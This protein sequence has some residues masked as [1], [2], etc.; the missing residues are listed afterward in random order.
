MS[1][2]Q[3]PR[4]NLGSLNLANHL[5]KGGQGQVTEVTNIL[6]NKQWPAV[7]KEYSRESKRTLQVSALETIAA[8]PQTLA[9]QDGRWLNENTAWPVALVED[10][11]AVCGFL[12]RAVPPEF[13]FDFQTQTMG[14][15][16]KLA[17]MAFLLNPESYVW[18]SGI[19]VT[20]RDR[21]ALL[22]SVASTLSLLHAADIAIG[23]FSPKN[24]LF[25]LTPVPS[26]F[27]IDCD[28]VRLRGHTVLGQTE[29]PDWEAPVGEP[30]ATAATDAYKFG[31]LAIR[32]FAHDQSSRDITA[33]T[34]VAPE[35]G[36]LARLSQ[37]PDPR[38]RPPP[39]TWI[40]ALRAAANAAAATAAGPVAPPPARPSWDSVPSPAFSA[41]T[42]P[43][44]M[45]P[46]VRVPPPAPARQ[47]T[48][49]CL[50]AVMCLVAI[51]AVVVGVLIHNAVSSG[52]SAGQLPGIGGTCL[53]SAWRGVEL[54]VL[55]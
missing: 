49:G 37:H 44:A 1:S 52:A 23:D 43:P 5:G 31:L 3:V 38:R 8:F 18:R 12:M 27:L 51:T 54:W 53:M 14:A 19:V 47:G 33:L 2:A 28:A 26:C 48:G 7:L 10:N 42:R 41:T 17:D 6:L 29:T 30:R 50:L 35:L 45:P 9:Y 21:L 4:F 11:G 36:H 39:G 24:V 34:A 55:P 16:K 15:Q 20:N 25:S 40:T 13:Y 32:L 22:G 46:A